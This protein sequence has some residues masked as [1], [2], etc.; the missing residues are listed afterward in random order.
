MNPPK[1]SL[2]GYTVVNRE[3]VTSVSVLFETGSCYMLYK[4]II[5]SRKASLREIDDGN[6]AT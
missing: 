1:V 4:P 3:L 6:N 2:R 5:L